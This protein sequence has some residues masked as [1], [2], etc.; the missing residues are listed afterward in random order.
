M[1]TVTVQVPD[2]AEPGDILSITIDGEA[3]DMLLPAGTEPGD[4][5]RVQV[6]RC[7][8]DRMPGSAEKESSVGGTVTRVD[9]V[10]GKYL[11]VSSELPSARNQRDDD[12]DDDD[13]TNDGTYA[14]PWR[15]GIEMAKAWDIVRESL[16]ASSDSKKPKRVLELGAGLVVVGM[17]LATSGILDEDACER[18]ER[19][20][21]CITL[22]DLPAAIPLLE[23]NVERNV[24]FLPPTTRLRIR[25]LR[26]LLE[27]GDGCWTNHEPPFDCLIGSDLLYDAVNIP[28][29]VATAK[30]LLHPTKGIFALAVRWRKPALEREFF[31]EM[32]LDWELTKCGDCGL[33]WEEFGDPSSA[34]SNKYFHQTQLSLG[35]GCDPKSLS[36]ISEEDVQTL[37][38]AQFE[39]WERSYVQ[40][41]VGK[42]RS[43]K[44]EGDANL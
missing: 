24:G 34:A 44:A 10:G 14:H 22:T 37:D 19:G 6:T 36:H 38:D 23:H 42:P 3:L 30:R 11:E 28:T 2:D 13:K 32:A 29:L 8:D 41:Y 27:R 18:D 39:A 16:F 15:S 26:W 25:P 12:D 1:R 17:S 21:V 40:I 7:N 31:R 33:S 20:E 43:S 5:L 9:V 4:S 35:E